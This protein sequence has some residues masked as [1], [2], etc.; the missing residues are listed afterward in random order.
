MPPAKIYKPPPAHV[1]VVR[2]PWRLWLTS[3]DI[4]VIRLHKYRG[5]IVD[6]AI[7]QLLAIDGQEHQVAR[8]DCTGGTIHRHQFVASTGSDIWDHRL[9]VEIPEEQ[10]WAV[11]TQHFAAARQV[12]IDEFTENVERWVKS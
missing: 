9:I 10:P 3:T 6:F 5:F 12:M 8:I 1:G 2:K 7:Q 4:L 11:I